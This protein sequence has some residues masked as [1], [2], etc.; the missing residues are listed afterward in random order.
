MPRSFT[1][2]IHSTTFIVL[3]IVS[4]F[5]ASDVVTNVFQIGTRQDLSFPEATNVPDGSASKRK[6]K[7]THTVLMGQFNYAQPTDEV[8]FWYNQW[9]K[10]FEHIVV[11][12]P[13]GDKHLKDIQDLQIN[14]YPSRNDSGYFSPTENLMRTLQQFKDIKDIKGVLSIHDDLLLNVTEIPLGGPDILS[15]LLPFPRPSVK[16]ATSQQGGPAPWFFFNIYPNRTLVNAKD[17]A[18]STISALLNTIPLW[19]HWKQCIPQLLNVNNDSRF[20]SY[21]EADGSIFVPGYGQSDFLYV[22]TS[23]AD[24]FASAAQL[25]LDH[26]VFLECAVPKLIDMLHQTTGV[27]NQRMRLCT[28]WDY[29]KVRGRPSMLVKCELPVAV[30]HPYKISRR[31]EWEWEKA[32]NWTMTGSGV[33]A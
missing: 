4:V 24:E 19:P 23:L 17:G 25:L 12:G 31:G 14:V 6:T 29:D 28:N 15:N 3:A 9:S 26:D 22:P 18:T 5:K 32:L 13:F 2:V 27:Q 33:F 21:K 7:I 30:V 8:V 1:N 20:E 10:W 16:N 11:F